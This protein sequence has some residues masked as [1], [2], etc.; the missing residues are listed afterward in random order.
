[1]KLLICNAGSTSLKFKLWEMPQER[2][3]CE[4]KVERIGMPGAIF[5][6][7]NA[8]KGVYVQQ[9]D[10]QIDR[11]R[12]GIERFLG[13]LTDAAAGAVSSLEEIEAIGFKTVLAKGYYGVHE[14]DNDVIAG[15]EA[16]YPVA[17]AH[18]GPYLEAI[19]MFRELLPNVRQVGAFE[20]A[21]HQTI[22]LYRRLFSIPYDWYETYGIMRMGYH[23][24]SHRYVAEKTGNSGR[25]ISCHLGGSGSICAILDGKSIDNSFGFSLQTGLAHNNRTGDLDPF[26]LTF[27]QHQ[28]IS[29][30]EIEK[31][32]TKDSGLKGISGISGDVRD[33]E[34]AQAAGDER[35]RLALDLFID[36]I[37][38]YI[39]AYTVFLRGLDQLV[40]T[41]GIGE[42][43]AYVRKRVCESLSFMG[44]LL[45]EDKNRALKKEGVITVEK[46]PV[47]ARVI[48]A[49]EE[50]MVARETFRCLANL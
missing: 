34:R 9:N 15:L 16:Y 2:A 21:F 27:L 20:T 43:S 42:N 12:E 5:S 13:F 37:I 10:L 36:A 35:A 3:L 23:G 41:G 38:R 50:L 24:A 4:A 30:E 25:V 39:G 32:L 14:I 49:G 18:N 47:T 6:Y 1:M 26:V 44:V 31:R 33:L 29:L 7:E 46:S 28:G 19:R 17:P 40:F 11:Y 48:P 22:P 8:E 45:D